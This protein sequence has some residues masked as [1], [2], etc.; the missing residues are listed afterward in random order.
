MD[1][2]NQLAQKL[3][4]IEA[5]KGKL[6]PAYLE[7]ATK[8]DLQKDIDEVDHLIKDHHELYDA[9]DWVSKPAIEKIGYETRK[10]QIGT[11]RD[12]ALK[13][14]NDQMAKL[15][16][17]Q[18]IKVQQTALD[19]LTEILSKIQNEKKMLSAEYFTK[20]DAAT[21]AAKKSELE[22]LKKNYNEKYGNVDNNALTVEQKNE[23]PN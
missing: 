14:L 12:Q 1:V 13:I 20:T 16:Q 5:I 23:T 9:T 4:G 2:I 11:V 7:T 18:E 21:I 3:Q 8:A 19:E 17:P 6:T 15:N 22:A 10:D